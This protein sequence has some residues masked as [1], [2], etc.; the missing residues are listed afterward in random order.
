MPTRTLGTA[1]RPPLA[2]GAG[3]RAD[4]LTSC[5]TRRVQREQLSSPGPEH[6]KGARLLNGNELSGVLTPQRVATPAP[7]PHCEPVDEEQERRPSDT[8]TS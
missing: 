1:T 5:Y 2:A 3:N 4:P 6:T 7:E 8:M